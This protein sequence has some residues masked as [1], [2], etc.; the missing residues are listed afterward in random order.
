MKNCYYGEILL[1][2]LVN[3]L[4]GGGPE[5]EFIYIKQCINVII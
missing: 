4:S 3:K 2:L 5:I 1:N